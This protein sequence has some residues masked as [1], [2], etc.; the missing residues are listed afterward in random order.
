[1]MDPEFRLFLEQLAIDTAIEPYAFSHFIRANLD[2]LRPY[3]AASDEP[4]DTD[5]R[6]ENCQAIWLRMQ[7]KQHERRFA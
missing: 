7:F 4:H 5:P 3:F 2:W 1:M 6:V